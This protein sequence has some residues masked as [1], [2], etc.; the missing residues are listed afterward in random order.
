MVVKYEILLIMI[1]KN[2][3]VHKKQENYYPNITFLIN[4]IIYIYIVHI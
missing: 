3:S 1:G 2:M 4:T